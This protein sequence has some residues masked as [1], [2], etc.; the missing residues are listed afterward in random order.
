MTP[1]SNASAEALAHDD[2]KNLTAEA[3][4][5]ELP[6]LQ[7]Y[8]ADSETLVVAT[9]PDVDVTDSN[10]DETAPPAP[11]AEGLI[12]APEPIAEAHADASAVPQT[13][14]NTPPVID[15]AI[16]NAPAS[17]AGATPIVLGPPAKPMIRVDQQMSRMLDETW[18][19]VIIANFPERYFRQ[20]K[21]LTGIDLSNPDKPRLRVYTNSEWYYELVHL[22]DWK[23]DKKCVTPPYQLMKLMLE[24][25]SPKLPELKLLVTVPVF[26]EDG[27]LVKQT[28]YNSACGIY[29]VPT[30]SGATIGLPTAPSDDQV[31]QAREYL[32]KDL[33]GE[34]RFATES[35]EAHALACILLPFVKP[36]LHD[37]LIPGLLVKAS[38]PGAGKTTLCKVVNIVATGY[39][40][41]IM[42]LGGSDEEI[43]KRILSALREG[44]FSVVFDNLPV[45]RTVNSSS[46]AAAFTTKFY[47]DRVLG[48]SVMLTVRNDALIMMT[49]NNPQLTPELLRRTIPITLNSPSDWRESSFN[50]IDILGWANENRRHII[51]HALTLVQAWVS[52]GMP[53]YS[54]QP[55]P[56]YGRWCE[57]MGGI[58]ENAG[59][60]GFLDGLDDYYAENNAQ[61]AEFE[62][63]LETWH[64]ELGESFVRVKQVLPLC[65]KHKLLVD[66]RGKGTIKSQTT[67]LGHYLKDRDGRQGGDYELHVTLSGSSNAYLV[68]K[69]AGDDE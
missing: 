68:M 24:N 37:A 21:Y 32:L 42:A 5:A 34:F 51:R 15:P 31:S 45:E 25:V 41:D 63:L 13:D 48:S 11:V 64:R 46:L 30:C 17:A 2:A 69:M 3:P 29:Y 8:D 14:P 9:D 12:A 50:R 43:R 47:S 20:G 53:T 49:G 18:D 26:T 60:K 6:C 40:G 56:S 22:A 19:E 66:V 10:V 59:V 36:M 67:K 44:E 38:N 16:T 28:A 52:K 62:Q 61:E 58:L 54:G 57:I 23:K 1:S 7:V 4:S 35:D 27:T 39:D 55:L 33:L 65:E